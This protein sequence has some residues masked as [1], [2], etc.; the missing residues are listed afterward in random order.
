MEIASTGFVV[1][2]KTQEH[3]RWIPI[4]VRRYIL[5]TK[6]GY[7]GGKRVESAHD[8]QLFQAPYRQ[9]TQTATSTSRVRGAK[10]KRRCTMTNSVKGIGGAFTEPKGLQLDFT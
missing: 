7:I 6:S 2:Y 3:K 10:L 9:D 8:I 1:H 5:N 4:Y